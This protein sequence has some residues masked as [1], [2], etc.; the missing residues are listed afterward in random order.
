MSKI[1]VVEKTGILKE[2]T[3]KN[4]SLQELYKKAGLKSPD[5]FKKI[6]TWKIEKNTITLFAKNTGRAGQENKYD[7]PP[8]VDN[9][10]FFGACILVLN[11]DE[12]AEIIY[13]LSV[14]KWE[15]MYEFLFG[16]FEDLDDNEE[17]S[18]DEDVDSDASFTKDGYMK[19]GFIVDDDEDEDDDY[20]EKK[21]KEKKPK[22]K[23]PKEKKP[24]AKKSKK[25][26]SEKKKPTLFDKI[27]T[28][29]LED[30]NEKDISDELM[31]EEY[32]E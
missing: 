9:M 2:T 14:P 25:T 31:E 5:N 16:G 20:E 17:E 4:F 7:F 32:L 30:M 27:E 28:I 26:K 8:P 22:E 23:K 12:D 11:L 18:E 1:V 6:H 21:P 3:I 24:K 29:P 10:L 15:K 13:D 19:D